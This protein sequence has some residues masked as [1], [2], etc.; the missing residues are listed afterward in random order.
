MGQTSRQLS[1]I[2]RIIRRL[3]CLPIFLYQ[4]LVRPVMRP[5]CRFYPSCS[6][7]ALSAIQYHGLLIGAKLMFI[8]IIRCHPW[9][10]GGYDPIP[11]GK[12]KLH[13]DN[14]SQLPN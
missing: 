8:R 9:A 1:R 12:K 13:K 5:C 2:N 6:D 10:S 4:L 7:Y 3:I 14:D 11:L